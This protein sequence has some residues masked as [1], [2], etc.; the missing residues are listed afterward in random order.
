MINKNINKEILYFFFCPKCGKFHV[1]FIFRVY[2]S[3]MS[4]KCLAIAIWAR[5]FH[6]VSQSFPTHGPAPQ[7]PT[8]VNFI[9]VC[10][11]QTSSPSA[12]DFST[13]TSAP[14]QSSA[15]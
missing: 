4:R 11:L 6:T 12:N 5:Q 3:L 1:C 13:F 9:L 10:A 8:V 15:K 2:L 7:L 14:C